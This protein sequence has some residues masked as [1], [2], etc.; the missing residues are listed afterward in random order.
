MFILNK[1]KK[2]SSYETGQLVSGALKK[3]PKKKMSSILLVSHMTL[4]FIDMVNISTIETSLLLI[5]RI[6]SKKGLSAVLAFFTF[7]VIFCL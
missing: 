4:V 1:K 6:C 7:F 3:Y 2:K 5:S